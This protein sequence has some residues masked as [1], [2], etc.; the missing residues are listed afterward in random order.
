M[1][2]LEILR[3]LADYWKEEV[4]LFRKGTLNAI[5]EKDQRIA[6]ILA[7]NLTKHGKV[8]FYSETP[9]SLTDVSSAY[10]LTEEG[11]YYANPKLFPNAL[12]NM[13]L[14]MLREGGNCFFLYEGEGV[15]E[16]VLHEAYGLLVRG[17]VAVFILPDSIDTKE[18]KVFDEVYRY[19][20]FKD[21]YE[22]IGK[23]DRRLYR[24]G[25]DFLL[26]EEEEEGEENSDGISSD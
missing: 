1:L 10:Y 21:H 14:S 2:N 13:F 24:L 25:E 11:F 20:N 26:Y 4:L 8:Y 22:F 6:F 19:V 12:E 18:L 17:H 16:K 5:L 3:K 9:N 15:N 23:H 7:I